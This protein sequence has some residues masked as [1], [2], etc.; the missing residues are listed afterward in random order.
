MRE[1]V[2]AL[3]Q[4]PS[5]DIQLTAEENICFHPCLHGMYS[6]SPAFW[7][8]PADYRRRVNELVE[9][10][11]IQDALSGTIKKLSGDIQSKLKIIR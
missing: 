7:I 9:I 2:G 3:F 4:H 11:G 8:V 5:L 1:K 6:Y 10:I